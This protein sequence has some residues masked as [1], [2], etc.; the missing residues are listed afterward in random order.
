VKTQ[1][2]IKEALGKEYAGRLEK[3]DGYDYIPWPDAQRAADEAFD[4][5]GYSVDVIKTWTEQIP[6]LAGEVSYGY[7]ALVRVTVQPSDGPSFY[8]DGLGFS[9]V[10]FAKKGE[11]RALIDSAIKGCVSRALVRA[12][13][14]FGDAF[15]LKLY[16]KESTQALTGAVSSNSSYNQSSGGGSD[17]RPSEK[18]EAML[19]GKLGF[20]ADQVS[21][22]PFSLWKPI[23]DDYF[24]KMNPPDIRAKYAKELLQ[25]GIGTP[26]GDGLPIPA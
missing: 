5:D 17:K 9:E 20:R 10:V 4:P 6:N 24:G 23:L 19:T 14:L 25:L 1:Q 21:K 12:L 3:I 16:D 2:E 11:G 22:M 8:R 7:A 15:G 18:Q 13:T 26:K